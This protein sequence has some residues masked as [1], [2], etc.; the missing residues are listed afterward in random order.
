MEENS[1]IEGQTTA[2][3]ADENPTEFIGYFEFHFKTE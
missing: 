2:F 3:I 1:R